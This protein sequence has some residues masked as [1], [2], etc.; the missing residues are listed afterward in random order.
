[1]RFTPKMIEILKTYYP[2]EGSSGVIK[3]IYSIS[4]HTYSGRSIRQKAKYLKIKGFNSSIFQK[5]NPP[6]NKGKKNP[7]RKSPPKIDTEGRISI[8]MKYGKKNLFIKINGIYVSYPRY[9]YAL[10]HG[11]IPKGQGIVFINGD[12][13]DVSIE[14]LKLESKSKIM[15]NFITPEVAKTRGLNRRINQ[16]GYVNF[17]LNGNIP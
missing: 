7:N 1:M 6:P 14:N 15:Q 13:L 5:G 17:I 4:G 16:V 9:I 10:H 2:S 11:E 12:R 8:R 3:R